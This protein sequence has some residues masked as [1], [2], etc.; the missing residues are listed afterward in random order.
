MTPSLPN[1]SNLHEIHFFNNVLFWCS[2]RQQNNACRMFV[3]TAADHVLLFAVDFMQTRQG[4]EVRQSIPEHAAGAVAACPI[5]YAT[6]L[7]DCCAAPASAAHLAWLPTQPRLV[8]NVWNCPRAFTVCLLSALRPTA[9][10]AMM[11]TYLQQQQQQQWE[12]KKR[13]SLWQAN[14]CSYVSHR[15]SATH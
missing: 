3:H 1:T 12:K 4:S 5:I 9:L 8:S 2:T 10:P 7:S 14:R 11:G 15:M 13:K 6:M